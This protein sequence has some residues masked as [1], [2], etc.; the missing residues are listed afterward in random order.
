MRV[1]RVEGY[2]ILPALG[3]LLEE[4]PIA[5]NRYGNMGVSLRNFRILRIIHYMFINVA[6]VILRVLHHQ[7]E[8]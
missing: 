2:C 3:C 8:N 7:E 6:F 5:S 4:T 1:E